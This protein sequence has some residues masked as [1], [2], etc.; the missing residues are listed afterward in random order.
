VANLLPESFNLGTKDDLS[1]LEELDEAVLH[2]AF[3]PIDDSALSPHK[4]VSKYGMAVLLH[5]Y[6][7]AILLVCCCMYS[8]P[9]LS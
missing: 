5:M 7:P 4:D 8:Q 1:H 2:E 3:L 6:L 9:E